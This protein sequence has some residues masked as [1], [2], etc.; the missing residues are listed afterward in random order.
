MTSQFE[1][2]TF[3]Q[4]AEAL[5]YE[6]LVP[7][8]IDE[9]R[10]NCILFDHNTGQRKRG[11]TVNLNGVQHHLFAGKNHV[12]KSVAYMIRDHFYEEQDLAKHNRE[13]EKPRYFKSLAELGAAYA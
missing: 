11:L 8:F 9:T 2:V 6:P 3:D 4:S 1:I 10:C 7:V 12:P 5:K 13:L